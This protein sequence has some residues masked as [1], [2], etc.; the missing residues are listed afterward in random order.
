MSVTKCLSIAIQAQFTEPMAPPVMVWGGTGA[1][2]T[3]STEALCKSLGVWLDV[4]RVPQLMEADFIGYPVPDLE[5]GA[6]RFLPPHFAHA[7]VNRTQ[8]TVFFFDELSDANRSIQAAAHGP[9]LDKAFGEVVLKGVAMVAASNPPSISTTGQ[10]ISAPIS[11]RLVHLFWNQPPDEWMQGMISG[12]ANSPVE[13]L[14]SNWREGIPG[15]RALVAQFASK[16]RPELLDISD[17][18]LVKSGEDMWKP[19]HTRRSWTHA[20]ILMAAAESLNDVDAKHTLLD[21]CVGAASLEYLQWEANLDLVDPELALA[22]PHSFTMPGRGDQVL[23]L[24]NSVAARVVQNNTRVRWEAGWE[25]MARIKAAGFGD[26]AAVGA[27]TLCKNWP[28]DARGFPSQAQPFVA[29]LQKAG[30]LKGG[31]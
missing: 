27:P 10:T 29:L 15:K 9:L 12:L 22:S 5:T 3:S 25:V 18:D 6:M 8:K 24:A 19:F 31:L 20:A 28:K 11:N 2:K 4:L 26:V 7:C 16:V 17:E 1:G 30:L 21:G 13:K 14:P 23:A